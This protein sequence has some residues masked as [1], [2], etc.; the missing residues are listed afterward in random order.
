[1]CPVLLWTLLRLRAD[2]A[3]RA[4]WSEA[5]YWFSRVLSV[6][7]GLCSRNRILVGRLRTNVYSLWRGGAT[8]LFYTRS[9][10]D[11]RPN[12]TSAPQISQGFLCAAF[13]ACLLKLM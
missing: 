5:P 1:M 2:S 4:S 10:L 7:S 9:D 6:Q 12:S 8:A 3:T 13:C 11:G